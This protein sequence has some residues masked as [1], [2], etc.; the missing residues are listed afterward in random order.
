MLQPPNTA[1]VS[2]SSYVPP[3][4]P[5]A[6]LRAALRGHY[7]I[8]RE[9]GQGAFAV[10]YLAHDLKHERKVALKVL[11]AD[12][13]S[14][15]GEL[16]F[17]REIR[18][19]ARLQ[20]PHILPLHDSGHVEALLY[21]VMPYV[22]GDTLRDRIDREKQLPV[23]IACSIAR[24]VADALAYAHAQGIIHRDIKPENILLSARHPILAD[25]GIARVLDLAGVRTLTRTGS[26]SPG[27][28]AYMSPEQLLGDREIDGRTDTYSLGCVLFEM[29]TGKPPFSGKDGF[30]KR[31][32]EPP[33]SVTTKRKDL[34][35]SMDSVIA[36]AMARNPSDRYQTAEEFV[37]ALCAPGLARS[38]SA[39][40]EISIPRDVGKEASR[41]QP[42]VQRKQP[43]SGS[44]SD[45]N[46]RPAD[47]LARIKR[48]RRLQFG[49][50]SLAVLT[51]LLGAVLVSPAKLTGAF[52]SRV[53]LDTA[54]LVVIPLGDSLGSAAIGKDAADKLYE[55][56]GQWDGVPLVA[57]T[58]VTQEIASRGRAPSTEADALSIARA[59]GAGKLVWGQASGTPNDARVRVNLYDVDTRAIR[60]QFV[61]VDS[62]PD[63][64]PYASAS[65]RLL[66]GRKR[67]SAADGANAL[68]HSYPALLGY[69][70]AHTALAHWDLAAAESGF[71]SAIASDAK[72]APAHL[73]LAQILQWRTPESGNEWREHVVRARVQGQRLALG[74]QLLSDALIA[75]SEG[76][77]P[78]ACNSYR[79]LTSR[80]SSSFVGW[81]GLGDCQALDSLVVKNPGSASGWAFRSSFDAAGTAY[82]KAF[83]IQPAALSRVSYGR[84]Q[85]VLP[86]SSTRVRWG[87]GPQPQRGNFLAYPS[88]VGGDTVGYVPYPA[89]EFATVLPNARAA[90]RDHNVDAL[91]AVADAW[92]RNAPRNPDA[93]EAFEDALEV[94][95]DD[96]PGSLSALDAIRAARELSSD[97]EQR[98]RLATREV[99]LH[100]KKGEFARVSVQSDSLLQEVKNPTVEQARLLLPLAALTGKVQ[101]AAALA[102]LTAPYVGAPTDF[103]QAPIR[104]AAGEL[105]A[106][107]SMGVCDE[108]VR[109]L[110]AELSDNID[111]HVAEK[112]RHRI[113]ASLTTRSLSMLV[114]CTNGESAR[115]LAASR[116]MLIQLQQAYAQK[117]YGRVRS[118]FTSIARSR[119]MQRPADISLDRTYQEAWLRA[120]IGD[121]A[122]AIRQLDQTLRSLRDLGSLPSQD[123]A[124]VAAAPRAMMLRAS[125]AANAGDQPT[126]A[127]WARAV[128]ELWSKAD[129]SLSTFVGQMRSFTARK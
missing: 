33:P 28:P 125:L 126:A 30:V 27:T 92:R 40:A 24:E 61:I 108:S 93:Y 71:R 118:L 106:E 72:F 95:G 107:A 25:F 53:P 91:L 101:T 104:N 96:R 58:R 77:Y 44:E 18:T 129:P 74:D 62:T 81:F 112:D 55:A 66:T 8:E 60:D 59:L 68:T 76:R 47:F 75:L 120:A 64:E 99:W 103:L 122:E 114:P 105:F 86:A 37:T 34:S 5:I 17:I 116:D 98:L 111:S 123:P 9:I 42:N 127:L 113:R 84:L 39:A 31:F 1:N 50:A 48:S 4:D 43:H 65:I 26:Q 51:V 83:Q 49:V 54:R 90:A 13:T 22:S 119:T 36:K 110:Q 23:D 46:E 57:D 67:V 20:H 19:L 15:L 52:A 100:F 32:T 85:R 16:R 89:E 7:D 82:R 80:D 87:F 73:W 2:S 79:Q 56:I 6:P 124:A 35:P 10:V 38:T 29:L 12:P 70:R 121:T 11:N 14:E 3:V 78:E 45:A 41:E 97:P 69:A 115:G 117:R 63:A 109:R 21:Y 102:S 88:L 128:I 94:R